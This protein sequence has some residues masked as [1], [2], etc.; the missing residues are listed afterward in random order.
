[1]NDK[2]RKGFNYSGDV[3]QKKYKQ[4]LISK[5][6]SKNGSIIFSADKTKWYAVLVLKG[7]FNSSVNRQK[8]LGLFNKSF[9]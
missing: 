7:Q 1:M 6:M 4:I 2:V 5:R 3:W 9:A 8:C